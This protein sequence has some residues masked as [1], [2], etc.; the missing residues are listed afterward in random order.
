MIEKHHRKRDGAVKV[1]FSI[2]TDW[3]DRKVSVV[4]DFNG[5]DPAANPLRKHGKVRRVSVVLDADSIHRFRYLDAAGRWYDDPAADY[6]V[7]NANGGTD[8]V[9]D[10]RDPDD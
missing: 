9:L 10:L 8:A 7:G 4:G 5:W 6:V 3:L 2:P 1:T